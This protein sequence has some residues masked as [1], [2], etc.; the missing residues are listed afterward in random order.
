MLQFREIKGC[1][2]DGARG[3]GRT[4]SSFMGWFLPSALLLVIPKC[5]L[6]VVA[7]T[8]AITGIGIS[9]TTAAGI[10]ISLIAASLCLLVIVLVRSLLRVRQGV[11]IPKLI[12]RIN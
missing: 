6:C 3:H 9:V 1:C 8:A 12:G 4:L 11:T 2:S 5:P 10:R 7:Y